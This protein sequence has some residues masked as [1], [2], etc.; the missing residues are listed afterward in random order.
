MTHSRNSKPTRDHSPNER[1]STLDNTDALSSLGAE[2]TDTDAGLP[3]TCGTGTTPT[4][5]EQ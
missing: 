2:P 3:P 4:C 5:P 1:P